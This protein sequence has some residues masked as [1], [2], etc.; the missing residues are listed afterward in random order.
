[1]EIHK[2]PTQTPINPKRLSWNAKACLKILDTVFICQAS[3]NVAYSKHLHRANHTKNLRN[4]WRGVQI[5][6]GQNCKAYF[7]LVFLVLLV[8][9]FTFVCMCDLAYHLT[10]DL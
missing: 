3:M 9:L 5:A 10:G 7:F 1:M 6:L 8:F 2:R 4:V